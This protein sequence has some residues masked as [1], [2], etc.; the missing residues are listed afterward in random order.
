MAHNDA[1]RLRPNAP[2][3]GTVLGPI[4]KIAIGAA[5]EYRF[6]LGRS[7]F[8]MFVV[9]DAAERPFAYLNLCPH[10]SLPLNHCRDQFVDNGHIRCLQHFAIFRV[11]DGHCIAGACEGRS[12]DAIPI[13][14]SDLGVMTVG[15]PVSPALSQSIA[16]TEKPSMQSDTVH[17]T[18]GVFPEMT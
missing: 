11:E 5:K 3:V 10:F 6:G 13:D 15:Q 8:S 16:I 14:L 7:A 17:R 18:I 9:R 2:A 4:D 1:W 12:L